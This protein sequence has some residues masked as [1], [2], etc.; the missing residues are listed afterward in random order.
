MQNKKLVIFDIDGTLI[1]AARIER[2]LQRFRHAVLTV[3]HHDIGVVSEN[4]WK[5]RNYNGNGDRLILWDLVQPIGV[6]RD[7]FLDRLVDLGDALVSYLDSI[8][9]EGASY[10]VI[11]DAKKLLEKVIAAP[12]LSLGV[13]TGN[14]GI[15]ASWKLRITGL[16]DIAFGV[17]GHEADERDDL[18]RLIFPKAEAYYGHSVKAEDIIIVGDTVHDVRCA[19]AIGAQCIIVST[20]WNVQREDIEKEQPTLLVDSLL[21]STVLSLLGLT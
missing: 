8:Q 18:A 10:E 14:I 9:S 13:L 15:A 19:K 20:G 6:G 17:Y 1:R 16:P 21:D 5:E 7:E 4:L 12:H 2:N 3:F 11:P